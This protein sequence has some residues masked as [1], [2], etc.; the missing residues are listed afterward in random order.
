V[1]V[2]FEMDNNEKYS[3]NS[4]EPLGQLVKIYCEATLAAMKGQ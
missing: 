1:I 2:K 3:Q 4:N